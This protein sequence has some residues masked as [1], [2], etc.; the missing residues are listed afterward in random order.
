MKLGRAFS[1]SLILERKTAGRFTKDS[2]S[3]WW[4]GSGRAL[5]FSSIFFLAIFALLWRLFDLTVIRGRELRALAD[6]NRTRELIRHAPRGILF[7]RTGKPLVVNRAVWRLRKPC[8]GSDPCTKQLSQEEGEQLIREGLPDGWYLE[9]DYLRQYPHGEALAHVVGYLGELS[10]KE[11][12]DDY[13]ELRNYRLG[14]R[15]GRMGAE[16]V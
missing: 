14:D 2:S 11:L 12:T 3:N 7:D 8:E 10:D 13:Y 6:S 5:I 4:L 15:I 16:L 1:D 9:Q